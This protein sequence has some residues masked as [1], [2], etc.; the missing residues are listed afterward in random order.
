MRVFLTFLLHWL[1]DGMLVFGST[2]RVLRVLLQHWWNWC[3]RRDVTG[4]LG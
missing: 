2:S 1:M 3:H 4:P